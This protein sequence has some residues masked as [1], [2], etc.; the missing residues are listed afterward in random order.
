MKLTTV[1]PAVFNQ[2][3]PGATFMAITG[4]QNNYGELSNFGLVFHANYHNAVRKALN[5]WLAYS[6]KSP[7]E[8]T[9]KTELF[10]SYKLTLSG[11]NPYALSSHAYSSITDGYDRLI[12]GVKWYDNGRE[13]HLWGFR[14]AKR[15]LKPGTYPSSAWEPDKIARHKLLSMTPLINFR[16]FKLIEGRFNTVGVERLTLTHH[17]LLKDLV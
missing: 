4:Y 2:I 3:R 7:E 5:T 8:I 6:P 11:H 12:K 13:V 10:D 16:Q 15:I 17:D 1:I 14:V 9:A